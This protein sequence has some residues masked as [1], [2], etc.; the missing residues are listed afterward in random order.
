L[1]YSIV[2]P[3]FND[4]ALAS[5]FCRETRKVFASRL[6][7]RIADELE[8]IFVDDGSRNDSVSLLKALQE[9]YPFVKVIALSRNFGQHIAISCG[10]RHA[11]GKI[12]VYLNVDQ[13]D[14]PDQILV[15]TD[16]LE[17]NDWDIV[18]GLYAKRNVPVLARLTSYL[19]TLFLNRLTGYEQP[20][21][22]STLRAMNRR[23]IDAYNRLAE[24]SRY[25]PGL[26][27]WLGFKHGRVPVTHKRRSRGKSSYN[28][29]RRM[30]MAIE[31]II[32]FS[33]YP[34]RLTVK[35]GFLVSI[36]GV[37]LSVALVI[38]RMF[39]RE[40]LPG[41]VSTIAAIVLIGGA[42]IVVTGVA[43]LYLGRV[44]AEVQ[45]RPLY[46]VRERSGDLPLE[47]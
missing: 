34:L 10:Y 25:I 24:R 40:L 38:D 42:Q 23:F 2:V 12:V 43:S 18:G 36:A 19:F 21:N 13:E 26:E 30:R 3:I 17:K 7:D 5:D 28:F 22:A 11:R 8:V 46:I 44:L 45:G 6:R 16:A 32:S 14:P 35:F 39:L 47:D 31:S 9:E 20:T 27:M 33:D 41:Y 29:G 4:G 1:I 37:L 15:V